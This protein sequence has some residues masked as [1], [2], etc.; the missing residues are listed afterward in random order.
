MVSSVKRIISATLP[1][2]HPREVSHVEVNYTS[3][4]DAVFALPEVVVAW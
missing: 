2:G 4:D 3:D 1:D